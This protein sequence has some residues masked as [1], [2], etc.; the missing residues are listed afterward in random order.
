MVLKRVIGGAIAAGV[1]VFGGVNAM[2]D[3]TTRD[4]SGAIV[5]SGGLGAFVIQVGDCWNLPTEDYVA[6]VEAVPCG[7]PHDVETFAEVRVSG[8]QWPGEAAIVADG[9]AGCLAEYE[10]YVGRNYYTSEFGFSFLS[11]TQESWEKGGD[12]IVNCYLGDMNGAKLTGSM[13]STGR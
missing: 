1:A 7:E 5:E 9:E 4:E 3:E 6:S 13:R 2:G 8:S 10:P 11:P 12:R